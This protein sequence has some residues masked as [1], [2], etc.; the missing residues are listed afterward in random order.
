[1]K[2]FLLLLA[3]FALSIPSFASAQT[4]HWGVGIIVGEPTGVD[5]KYMFD[6]KN[7]LEAAA[8]WALSGNNEFQLQVD[9]L[10]HYYE[11]IKVDKGQ[12]PVFFGVGGRVKFRENADDKIG[13]RVPIGLSYIFEDER[14]DV[15]GEIVPVLELT[16]DTEFELEGAVGI[17][18]WF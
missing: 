16:P 15:F 6:K 1:M 3:V 10:Y 8:A 11:L 12:L 13:I 4:Y 14:F 7:G 2:R 18:F 5:A 17:R 9:Y